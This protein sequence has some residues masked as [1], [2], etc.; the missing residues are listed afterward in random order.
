[1]AKLTKDLVTTAMAELLG[2]D[3]A[4]MPL[5]RLSDHSLLCTAAGAW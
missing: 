2:G 3:V 1:M 4:V 5:D